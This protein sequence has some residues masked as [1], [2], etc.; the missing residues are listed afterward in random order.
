MSPVQERLVGGQRGA[1]FA[2]QRDDSNR[3]YERNQHERFFMISPCTQ[4]RR[5]MQALHRR[6]SEDAYE[7][8]A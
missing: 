6:E 2:K 1:G 5:V 3:Q 8:L 4:R 7:D